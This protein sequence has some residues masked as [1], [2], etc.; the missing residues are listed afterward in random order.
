[1]VKRIYTAVFRPYTQP[2]DWFGRDSG[3]VTEGL[4]SIGIDS[5]L[6]I[7][8]TPGMPSDERFLR[9]S[10]EQFCDSGFWNSLGVDAVVLQGGGEAATQPVADAIKASNAKL[11]YRMDTDGVVDPTVDPW[12]FFYGKW[13]TMGNALRPRYIKWE[14]KAWDHE[15]AIGVATGTRPVSMNCSYTKECLKLALRVA[16]RP[17]IV[18]AICFLKFISPK[19]FGGDRVAARLQKADAILVE[20][21]IASA[22]LQRLLCTCGYPQAASR[23]HTLPI[24]IPDRNPLR[25]DGPRED[26]IISAG[27]LY[28]DQKDA[29]LLVKVLAQFLT[30][31]QD[32]RATLIGD[33]HRYVRYLVQKYAG[34]SSKRIQVLP[35]IDRDDIH[36]LENRSKIFLCASRGEGFP[37][38]IAEAICNGCSVVGPSVIS[39]L[40]FFDSYPCMTV[41]RTRSPLALTDALL[42]EAAEWDVGRRKPNAMSA[43]YRDILNPESHAQ[44]LMKITSQL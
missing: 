5:R 39:A 11:I 3:L 29:K 37:N 31:R 16:L 18:P 8:D 44:Q 34:V 10:R 2:Y 13:W 12:L 4:R 25:P 42:A 43:Y 15:N 23:V 24:P 38:A 36:E 30:V 19:R 40:S 32:Y 14:E 17:A 6:V 22:R 28:D 27:R 9:A 26:V 7:L 35:R 41:S 20:S 1:M 21:K 33:G